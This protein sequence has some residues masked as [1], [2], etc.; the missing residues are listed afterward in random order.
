HNHQ[1]QPDVVLYAPKYRRL[2]SEILER[3]EFYVI[4]GRWAKIPLNQHQG[5]AQKILGSVFSTKLFTA[6]VQSTQRVEVMNRL[7]KEGIRTPTVAKSVFPKVVEMLKTAQLRQRE[8]ILDLQILNWIIEDYLDR[9]QIF[10]FAL[11]QDI[12]PSDIVEIWE[13]LSRR[14]YHDNQQDINFDDLQVQCIEISTRIQKTATDVI[15]PDFHIFEQIRGTNMDNITNQQVANKKVRSAN[16]FGKM[17]K[18]LNI[19]LNLQC[20]EELIN[21]T[22]ENIENENIQLVESDQIMNPLV[23]KYRGRPPIK[24]LK[25]SSESQN[26]NES[27]HT[28]CAINSRDMPF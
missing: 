20:K 11:M 25:C 3:I 2:S 21:V 1:M 16:S 24:R 17:K 7:I 14:W 13:L 23:T 27:A 10:I 8:D 28:Y 19:A 15:V 18:A 22:I 12:D 4:M 6:G 26:H 5:K 9:P